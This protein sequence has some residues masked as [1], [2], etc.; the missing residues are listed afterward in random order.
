VCPFF[1]IKFSGVRR[2]T[3][4]E[5]FAVN[6][7]GVLGQIFS[8]TRRQIAFTRYGM[9]QTREQDFSCG[10]AI[11]TKEFRMP[12]GIAKSG[13]LLPFATAGDPAKIARSP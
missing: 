4:I 12:A 9:A 5:R 7:L 10:K 6:I 13:L 8:D 3:V 2:G 1:A 11:G